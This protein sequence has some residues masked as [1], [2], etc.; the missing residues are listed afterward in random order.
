VRSS[1]ALEK[2]TRRNVEAMWLLRKLTPDFKT[3]AAIPPSTIFHRSTT[4]G[5]GKQTV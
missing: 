4:K 5:L 2:E 1:R 3:I